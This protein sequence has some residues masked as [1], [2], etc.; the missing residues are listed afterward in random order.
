MENKKECREK[1]LEIILPAWKIIKA[2]NNSASLTVHN[3][4]VWKLGKEWEV[5][6]LGVEFPRTYTA[7]PKDERLGGLTLFGDMRSR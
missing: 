2:E 4:P 7:K 6:A 1:K 3:F 5:K